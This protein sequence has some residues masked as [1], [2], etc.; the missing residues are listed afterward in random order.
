MADNNENGFNREQ[1]EIIQDYN[2]IYPK[3]RGNKL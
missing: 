1:P 2:K 3:H